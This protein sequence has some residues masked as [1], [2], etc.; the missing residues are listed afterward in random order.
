MA[1]DWNTA[2][3]ANYKL[4]K[5][6]RF[7]DV[8]TEVDEYTYLFICYVIRTHGTRNLLLPIR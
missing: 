6:E 4:S 2:P 7:N 1:A 3:M 5:V 8:E